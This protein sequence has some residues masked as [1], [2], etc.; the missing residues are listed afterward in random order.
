MLNN[1]DLNSYLANALTRESF[2]QHHAALLAYYQ[3]L[4]SLETAK[5][6]HDAL[7][8]QQN[9]YR[10]QYNALAPDAITP[11]TAQ[12]R[13]EIRQL[14]PSEEEIQA[15]GEKLQ[16]AKALLAEHNPKTSKDKG[17][18][19]ILANDWLMRKLNEPSVTLT[20]INQY[21]DETVTA[22]AAILTNDPDAKAKKQAYGARLMVLHE[23]Q[24]RKIMADPSTGSAPPAA[25]TLELNEELEE[26]LEEFE[27]LQENYV[28]AKQAYEEKLID[29]D[30][31]NLDAVQRAYKKAEREKL[32]ADE[33]LRVRFKDL[34]Y[35]DIIK[36]GETELGTAKAETRERE[37]NKAIDKLKTH[38]KMLEDRKNERLKNAWIHYYQNLIVYYFMLIPFWASSLIGRN[39]EKPLRPVQPTEA[40]QFSFRDKISI[41][42]SILLNLDYAL[43]CGISVFMGVQ[44]LEWPVYSS[45]FFAL[46]GVGVTMAVNIWGFRHNILSLLKKS[47]EQVPALKEGSDK[48]DTYRAWNVYRFLLI[49]LAGIAALVT[50]SLAAST[51]SGVFKVTDYWAS[52][53][54]IMTFG[55]TFIAMWGLLTQEPRKWFEGSNPDH[56]ERNDQAFLK[57]IVKSLKESFGITADP[58]LVDLTKETAETKHN[59]R[60]ATR[61]V[62]WATLTAVT[63]YASIMLAPR[64]ATLF[65]KNGIENFFQHI[66]A[67]ALTGGDVFFVPFCQ[68]AFIA[69]TVLYNAATALK[70]STFFTR[71]IY[72]LPLSGDDGK[73]HNAFYKFIY[74]ILALWNALNNGAFNGAQMKLSNENTAD[75]DTTTDHGHD[76]TTKQSSVSNL[77]VWMGIFSSTAR[78]GMFYTATRA[79]VKAVEMEPLERRLKPNR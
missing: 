23:A 64:A 65:Y 10:T 68:A 26:D 15:A 52:T 45:L 57:R 21:I 30:K 36:D 71:A 78:S 1:N 11:A 51:V 20:N 22:L 13:D 49:P 8:A 76:N 73:K 3:A 56:P 6:K 42:A 58:D 66:G 19:K 63:S 9:S 43:L 59:G 77:Q 27:R 35:K 72:R 18:T 31:T 2:N 79:G 62:L 16:Q 55:I 17:N 40:A 60:S 53:S 4:Y 75:P 7:I 74:P 50:T 47:I 12:K 48:E 32:E 39:P 24:A 25:S 54:L 38:K 28:E 69:I 37:L 41:V 46:A 29:S 67:E 34:D 70:L 14:I 44:A 33:W 5:K 61:F